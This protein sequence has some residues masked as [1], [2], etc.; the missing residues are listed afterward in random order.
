MAS[1]KKDINPIMPS[2][3]NTDC[4]YLSHERLCKDSGAFFPPPHL[5]EENRP[6]ACD[7][8]R[9]RKALRILSIQNIYD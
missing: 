2:S 4:P 8:T 5:H 9:E 1:G 7:F 6:D 3:E